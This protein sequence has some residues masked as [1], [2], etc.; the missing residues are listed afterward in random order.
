MVDDSVED[1]LWLGGSSAIPVL[2]QLVSYLCPMPEGCSSRAGHMPGIWFALLGGDVS[3]NCR[4]LS[5]QPL[6]EHVSERSG[7]KT[8]YSRISLQLPGESGRLGGF[9]PRSAGP[10]LGVHSTW[11]CHAALS[12]VLEMGPHS[13]ELATLFA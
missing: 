7:R 4:K 3:Q 11:A 12:R 10:I 1:G 5:S 2:G 8:S 6:C 13:S 9:S